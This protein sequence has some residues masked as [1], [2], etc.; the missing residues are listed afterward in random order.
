MRIVVTGAGGFIG[1]NLTRTLLERGHHVYAVTGREPEAPDSLDAMEIYTNP[2]EAR[3]YVLDRLDRSVTSR[4]EME[5]L[6]DTVEPEFVV[7]LAAQAIVAN[8]ERNPRETFEINVMGT[9]NV[10]EQCRKHDVPCIVSSTDKVYGDG[11]APFRES[12]RVYP[13]YTYDTSKAAA[14]L[15]AQSY[16]N[17][18]DLPVVVTRCCNVYGPGD[19]NWSRLVPYTCRQVL[20]GERPRNHRAM[21]RI[22]RE[23]MFIED[24]VDAHLFL[25]KKLFNGSRRHLI[26]RAFNV[27]SGEIASPSEVVPTI[28]SLLGSNVEPML[29]EREFK[30]L[31]DEFLDTS[32]IEKLGWKSLWTLPDGLKETAEWYRGYLGRTK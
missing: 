19:L 16:W 10:L 5:Y 4:E 21:W 31:G 13:S 29:V 17:T 24:A 9:V 8:A 23:Y 22:K 28:I 7:H 27:G 32:E 3:S 1:A 25:M 30:E 26:C 2:P 15:I 14:D 20:G 18:Y 12:D 11:V 6:F